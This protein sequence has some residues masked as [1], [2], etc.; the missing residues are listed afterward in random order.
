[1]GLFLETGH[2]AFYASYL[3]KEPFLSLESIFLAKLHAGC[4]KNRNVRFQN[5]HPWASLSLKMNRRFCFCLIHSHLLTRMLDNACLQ[6][7][8]A[9]CQFSK[10]ICF[11]SIE[12]DLIVNQLFQ[13]WCVIVTDSE[14]AS[15][16]FYVSANRFKARA[17]NSPPLNHEVV[18]LSIIIYWST[19]NIRCT[20]L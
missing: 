5:S 6:G 10:F 2:S 14:K 13:W 18:I 20:S 8:G 4:C 17:S 3:W 7:D 16:R 15:R 12:T 9:S 19:L 1:M 11:I